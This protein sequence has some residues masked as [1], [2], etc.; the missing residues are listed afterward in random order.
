[1]NQ[2]Y[3]RIYNTPK[4]DRRTA[5]GV[6]LS[7][8]WICDA[9]PSERPWMKHASTRMFDGECRWADVLLACGSELWRNNDG[10]VP[11]A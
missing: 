3:S 5:A 8:R 1:M 9:A 10:A 2:L 4:R 6:T 7:G 11:V